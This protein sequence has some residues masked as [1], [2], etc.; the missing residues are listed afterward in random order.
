MLS[1][2]KFYVDFYCEICVSLIFFP[3]QITFGCLFELSL[4]FQHYL[5]HPWFL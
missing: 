4:H 1:G 3:L 5:L 2:N